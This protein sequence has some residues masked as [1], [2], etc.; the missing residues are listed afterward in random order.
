MEIKLLK[1]VNCP[2]WV[3]NH[4]IGVSNKALE[5]A[6]NFD[7]VDKDLIKTGALLHDIGRSKTNSI[8]H[9]VIGAKMLEELG[10]S[11]EICLIVERHIGTGISKEEA[12]K[13]NL[14]PKSYVPETLEERIVS[15]SDNLYNGADEVSVDFTI[16]K[17][18]RKLG[19]NHPSI[20]EIKVIHKE[21]V[22]R[23]D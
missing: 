20:D 5:I 23:F 18:K 19:E 4:S 10:F 21:L 8:E 6:S 3:I 2:E 1:E 16:N 11:K 14:P 7:N 22:S 13:L 9:A 17:W 12:I 15:H